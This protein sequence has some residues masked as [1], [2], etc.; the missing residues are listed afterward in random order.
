MHPGNK[1]R[2][3]QAP[4]RSQLGGSAR[5]PAVSLTQSLDKART[6]AWLLRSLRVGV[7]VRAQVWSRLAG[8]WAAG[9]EAGP[10]LDCAFC[11]P[12]PRLEG[13]GPT[14]GEA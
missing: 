14:P 12:W 3:T 7:Q 5:I 13:A 2:D 4:A 6:V 1:F 11:L 9:R 10:S 8:R